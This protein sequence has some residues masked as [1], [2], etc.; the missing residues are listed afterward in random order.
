MGRLLNKKSPHPWFA[1]A[2]A[3]QAVLE[4]GQQD[5][6]DIANKTFEENT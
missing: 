6:I 3:M 2:L 4:S 1:L 5:A